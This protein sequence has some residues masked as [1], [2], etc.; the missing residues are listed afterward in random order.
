M[1]AGG[2]FFYTVFL[3]LYALGVRIASLFN[4]KAKKWLEGRRSWRARLQQ[5]LQ[6]G[7]KR[8][9][10]HCSSLG[11]FEQGRPVLEAIRQ[12]YPDYK[13]V[14]TFFSPSGYEIRK[15]Y[16]QADYVLYLPMDSRRNA[17]DFISMIDP[18]LV[19]YVK[20]EF[21]YHYLDTLKKRNIPLVLI[22]AAFRE[23]QAFFKPYGSF[24]RHMLYCFRYL[25]VQDERSRQLLADIGIEKNVVIGG[26][27][28]YDRVAGIAAQVQ[29]I[30]AVDRFRA[31]HKILIAGS[32]WPGDEAVLQQSLAA[33]PADWKLIIA[34]HEIDEAHIRKI[35][36][37]FGE[38]NTCL[39]SAMDTAKRI[40]IIDNIGMLSR[41]YACGDIAF[42]GG[43]FQKG[44][45]HNVLEPAVF[46][47][48]VIFGPVYEKFVEARELAAAGLVFPVADAAACTAIL[49]KLVAEPAYRESIHQ[50]LQQFI[51][52]H[53]GATQRVLDKIASERWLG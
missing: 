37:L 5:R 22:S 21:W 19:I 49:Q 35:Q 31:G 50:E 7:E 26:D 10:M 38:A 12:Q 42:I 48:P 11:E 9:W 14:L 18:S 34:P 20:Y 39:Y 41:L 24:F 4:G 43:G 51:Q 53:T 17:A 36:L 13:I 6:P 33:L 8:I 45:I 46:G 28:R 25:F 30:P 27:T 1:F 44:G 40:L 47:L 16:D 29:P 52:A 2:Y 3:A 32:T 15:D 23:S